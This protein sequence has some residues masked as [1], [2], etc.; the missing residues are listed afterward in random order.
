MNEGPKL[1]MQQ[2]ENLETAEDNVLLLPTDIFRLMVSLVSY[3][4][5]QSL[6][7]H[8]KLVQKRISD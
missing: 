7:I 3:L 6:F 5:Q 8:E 1:N 2:K 4:Q